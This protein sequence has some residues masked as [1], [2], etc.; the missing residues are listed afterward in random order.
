MY[1]QQ[2]LCKALA[3]TSASL[4]FFF[5]VIWSRVLPRNSPEMI[6]TTSGGQCVLP[7]PC[8]LN[9]TLVLLQWSRPD[10]K[11]KGCVFDLRPFPQHP[12]YRGRV[13]LKD[14]LQQL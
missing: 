4:L 6:N 12:S 9:F 3:L 8:P 1:P 14:P 11:D 10:V 2:T 5:P 7:C 13:H